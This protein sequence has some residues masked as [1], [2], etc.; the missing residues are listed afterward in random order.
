MAEEDAVLLVATLVGQHIIRVMC[1]AAAASVAAT[2]AQ[3]TY[4][5]VSVTTAVATTIVYSG[6]RVKTAVLVAKLFVIVYAV[7][8]SGVAMDVA[9]TAQAHSHSAERA[10]TESAIV[11]AHVAS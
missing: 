2:A 5:A 6:H 8:R 7:N 10:T 3:I 11:T 4:V 9:K 1:V